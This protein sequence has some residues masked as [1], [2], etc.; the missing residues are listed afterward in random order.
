MRR[1]TETRGYRLRSRIA[2]HVIR[3]LAILV[4]I[5]GLY[6]SYHLTLIHLRPAAAKDSVLED[7]CDIAPT[8]SCE[9]VL[10][11]PYA[12]FYFGGTAGFG[13]GEPGQKGSGI[14]TAE[15]GSL[16]FIGMLAWLILIGQVN[17]SR[18]WAHLI[19][20]VGA[21]AGLGFSVFF[22][23]IMFTKL[24]QW[25][26][27]CF[28]THVGSLLLFV[29]ALL[30]WPRRP[31]SIAASPAASADKS[32]KD[33]TAASGSL[34]APANKT[35]RA[36]G[37]RPWPTVFMLCITPVVAFLAFMVVQ[38]QPRLLTAQE[39]KGK[40]EKREAYYRGQITQM[41]SRYGHYLYGQLD[42]SF[43]PPLW[44]NTEGRP[45]R[46]PA[47]AKYTVVIFSDFQCPAC[48][49]FE[50]QMIPRIEKA[51]APHGGAKFI[52]LN[53]PI[54]IDCNPTA[55]NNLHPLACKAAFA[56]EA[57]YTVGGNDAFWKMHDMLFDRQKEWTKADPL[58][59]VDY[60]KEIGLDADRFVTAM[61]SK[62]VR[63]RVKAQVAEGMNLGKGFV[64]EKQRAWLK[65]HGTPSIF[66][67]NKR[68]RT[69]N[70]MSEKL[71]GRVLQLKTKPLTSRPA[72]PAEPQSSPEKD[73]S[74]SNTAQH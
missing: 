3:I 49:K 39:S 44:I 46:G 67:N 47:D 25:C 37:G 63:Q 7:F 21:T 23:V 57:A 54:C 58:P 11:S 52:F 4:A 74:P 55:A 68:L 51:A 73:E 40:A 36:T 30:L 14:P 43:S 48:R 32:G 42:Y 45:V 20:V 15:F 26:P 53:W 24:D 9:E 50:I 33:P 35:T 12:Y 41:K 19:F 28:S 56:V 22:D 66:V 62:E 8:S 59:F 17:V 71:W 60:A 38:L 70:L 61:D 34:F 13:F 6:V 18:W 29:F 2:R 72:P 69:E 64:K 1:V 65:V 16:F 31:A 10:K 5:L 27:L